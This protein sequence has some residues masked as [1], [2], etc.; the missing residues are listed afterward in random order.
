MIINSLYKKAT[1]TV[2]VTCKQIRYVCGQ[3]ILFYDISQLT[4]ECYEYLF[5]ENQESFRTALAEDAG[6]AFGVHIDP[7]R[8]KIQTQISSSPVDLRPSN[9]S[10]LD[11]ILKLVEGIVSN[12]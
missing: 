3:K 10:E 12:G 4:A 6:E 5:R 9:H 7:S 11:P 1:I 8:L 2:D